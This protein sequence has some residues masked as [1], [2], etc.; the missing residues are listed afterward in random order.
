MIT[1]A[2]EE[3]SNFDVELAMTQGGSPAESDNSNM[4]IKRYGI[5]FS[6]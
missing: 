5:L 3:L 1:K 4:I 2:V 6:L